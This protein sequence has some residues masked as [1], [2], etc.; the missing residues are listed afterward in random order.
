MTDDHGIDGVLQII[1]QIFEVNNCWLCRRLTISKMLDICLSARCRKAHNLRR[2]VPNP[3]M[4]S[5]GIKHRDAKD[6]NA[7]RKSKPSGRSDTN[8]NTCE[9]SGANPNRNNVE[10]FPIGV[11]VRQNSL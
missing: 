1:G 11:G 10:A 3:K 2:S 8:P 5:Q 9:I 6:W 7:K 4:I